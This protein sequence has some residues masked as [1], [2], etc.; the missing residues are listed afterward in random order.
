MAL[1]PT[2]GDKVLKLWGAGPV[3]FDS[4][5]AYK[6]AY[7]LGNRYK[8]DPNIIWILGGDRPA[9]TD[10]SDTRS[11]WRQMAKGIIDATNHQCFITYHPWGESS[12]TNFW[13]NEN[14]LDMNML[15]SGHARHDIPVW[16]WILR[17]R[18]IQPAKPILDG[19]PNYEDHPV[20]WNDKNGYFRAYDVRKQTYRSVF[21]GRLRGYLR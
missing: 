9:K 11:V 18:N 10:T 14:W 16:N 17:D 15:Q 13:K 2:W 3:I 21:A 6:Y 7:W 5:N 12:S 19:E 20:N 4:V 1:L 8:N